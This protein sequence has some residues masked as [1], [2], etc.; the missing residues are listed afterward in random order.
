M[1]KAITFDRNSA[2]RI[3]RAVLRAEAMASDTTAPHRHR[4]VGQYLEHWFCVI[5]AKGPKGEEDWDDERYWVKRVYCSN[6]IGDSDYK[7]G[8]GNYSTKDDRWR[9]MAATNLAEK[10]GQTHG[11]AHGTYGFVFFAYD[12]QDPPVKHCYF[13]AMPRVEWGKPKE[14]FASGTTITLE[15][16]DDAG[17]KLED[18]EE[19]IV[20]LATDAGTLALDFTTDDVL[21]FMRYGNASGGAAGVLVGLRPD[22]AQG[23]T[24]PT[25]PTG[26]QGPTG[27]AGATG[28]AGAQGPTGPEG[29]QGP[30]GPTGPGFTNGDTNGQ[31][32]WWN[33]SGSSW[34]NSA[35]NAVSLYMGQFWDGSQYKPDWVRGHA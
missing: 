13:M 6:V 1:S 31:I 9:H 33:Y 35:S 14:I 16:C 3:A 34:D 2:G 18:A 19:I 24:G 5:T 23:P 15:P 27:A 20:H 26:S 29:A 30:T 28:P 21:R 22:G 7:M 12:R 25:G 17:E 32:K 8:V 4:G 10:E 11:L